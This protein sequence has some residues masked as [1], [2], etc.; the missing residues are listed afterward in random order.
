MQLFYSILCMHHVGDLPYT[1]DQSQFSRDMH[2][3][4][5]RG[6]SSMGED[7]SIAFQ[8]TGTSGIL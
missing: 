4:E 8:F 1:L 7:S 2:V 3:I 5:F 6:I